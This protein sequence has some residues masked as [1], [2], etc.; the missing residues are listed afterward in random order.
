MPGTLLA[1]PGAVRAER[2]HV[3]EDDL[4]GGGDGYGEEQPHAAPKR[5][6]DEQAK[7]NGQR[8]ELQAIPEDFRVENI[9]SD[10]MQHK[11]NYGNQKQVG[12]FEVTQPDKDRRHEREQDSHIGDQAQEAAHKSD[13]IEEGNTEDCEDKSARG[14][15]DEAYYDIA[16]HETAN[17]GRDQ[18]Q[19]CIGS[20]AMLEREE[21]HRSRPHV[22]LPG[23]HEVGQKRHK[24][25]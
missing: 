23:Q 11:N 1:Q 22:L 17:H 12:K 16:H 9:Q 21:H 6:P 4:H 19:G 13:K 25:Y 8:V 3:V 10:E 15:D 2:F 24:G 18:S 7:S 14:S 5:A 20:V